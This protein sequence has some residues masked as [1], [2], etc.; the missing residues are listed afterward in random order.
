MIKISSH[1]YK[2]TSGVGPFTYQW[3]SPN[4]CVYFDK[5]S[6]TVGSGSSFV[7]DIFVS[8]LTCFQFGVDLI[9]LSLI[10]ANGCQTNHTFYPTNPCNNLSI[11]NI[12]QGPNEF[13]F[14]VTASGGDGNYNFDWSIKPDGL[15]AISTVSAQGKDYQSIHITPLNYGPKPTFFDITC[16]VTDYNGCKDSVTSRFPLSGVL[17]SNIVSESSCI[18]EGNETPSGFAKYDIKGNLLNKAV[19]AG[20]ILLSAQSYAP[21]CEPDWST[22]SFA[23]PDTSIQYKLSTNPTAVT[24]YGIKKTLFKNGFLNIPFTVLDCKG[25]ISNEAYITIYEA[26]CGD[27]ITGCPLIVNNLCI[28][29]CDTVFTINLEDLI[30][31]PDC[32]SENSIDWTT[33]D[34]LPGAPKLPA[35]VE[36]NAGNHTITYTANG[37]TEIADLI[38]W[39]I[40]D[41]LG[42]YSG[43]K[44]IQIARLCPAPPACTDDCYYVSQN[45]INHPLNV[46]ANDLGPN[47]KLDTLV[48]SEI[49]THG[50]AYVLNGDIYYTPFND[51]E[52]VDTIKYKIF[53]YD[54]L[55][56]EATVTLNIA[57]NGPAGTGNS[58]ITCALPETITNDVEVNGVYS[59]GKFDIIF[60]AYKND[61]EP[62]ENGDE[63][64]VE[65]I[66]SGTEIASATLIIG[67]DYTTLAGVKSGTDDQWLTGTN[68]FSQFLTPG[69][70]NKTTL[71]TGQTIK[72]NKHAW[73]WA[74][75]NVNKYSDPFKGGTQSLNAKEVTVKMKARSLSP[76]L[77]S[78]FDA[79]IIK[80]V[81]IFSFEDTSHIDNDQQTANNAGNWEPYAGSW[82]TGPHDGNPCIPNDCSSCSPGSCSACEYHTTPPLNHLYS[83]YSQIDSCFPYNGSKKLREY[84]QVGLPAVTG[85]SISFTTEDDLKN[86]LES[87]PPTWTFPYDTD[88][89]IPYNYYATGATKNYNLWGNQASYL[90]SSYMLS[91]EAELEYF[92]I[93]Y[94]GID[95]AGNTNTGAKCT[96]VSHIL[97]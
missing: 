9:T 63:L 30:K 54:G 73:A 46:L 59:D 23:L 65:I 41:A 40:K 14:S 94:D 32:C 38:R 16:V 35:T 90:S 57:E 6:G 85:L 26:I 78:G 24:F 36:Y 62:L 72:F 29:N 83:W 76:V 1:S 86:V 12:G 68:Y 13:D 3:S 42:N 81:K 70:L 82:S 50:T 48:I 80:T 25:A 11:T 67:Q 75:N 89:Y 56:C 19:Q 17:L 66:V 51:Y 2:P 52:G 37:S 97:F 58:I 10:D 39:G 69:V 84:K 5:P 93:S 45:A 21:G 88:G 87:L 77:E 27:N 7:T 43:I 15:F 49:P 53:N 64:D 95:A 34:I 47:L 96:T 4:S 61:H 79:D 8:D 31:S 20:P 91:T 71:V 74:T 55:S 92:V 28:T 33:F 18:E 22:I 60:K 44:T